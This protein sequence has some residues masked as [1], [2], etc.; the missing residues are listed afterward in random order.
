MHRTE[1]LDYGIVISGV[2]ECIVEG[3][4]GERESRV[5]RQGD[6]VV[7]RGT[8]HAWRVVGGEWARMCFVMMKS[9]PVEV[10]GRVLGEDLSAEG[11]PLG[12]K[13]IGKGKVDRKSE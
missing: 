8:M 11:R 3:E 1:S 13:G 7:Q 6:V 2:V 12:G 4:G 5:V 9:E 10:G